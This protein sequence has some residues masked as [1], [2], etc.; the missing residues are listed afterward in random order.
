MRK[1][2][3]YKRQT[4]YQRQKE[5]HVRSVRTLETVAVPDVPL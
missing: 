2:E 5:R 3:A 4:Y 1:A